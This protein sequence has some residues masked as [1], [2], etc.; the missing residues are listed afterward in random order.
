ME[1][2]EQVKPEAVA[3]PAVEP[4]PQEVKP[5]VQEDIVTRAARLSA[6]KKQEVVKEPVSEF[7]LAKED[8]DAV[9][10][11]PRTEKLY[12]SMQ[13]DYVKK[14]QAIAE[15]KR[16]LEAQKKS[17]EEQAKQMSAWTPDKLKQ[18]LNK[19]DFV[20]A[21]Q[22]VTGTQNPPNSGLTNEE[23]SALTDKEK[24][25][26]S[27]ATQRISNLEMQNWQM[28]Q[29]QQDEVLRNKYANYTPEVIDDTVGKLMRGEI[30]ADREI[31]YKA[32]FHDENVRN[33]YEMGKQDKQKEYQEK[34]GSMSVDGGF[35]T[36]PHN[37]TLKKE[38]KETTSSY[39]RRIAERR[40]AE[41]R[42]MTR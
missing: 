6:D 37:D 20:Q 30:K 13:A 11:D 35:S 42:Q 33:A 1:V 9:L 39:F 17:I 29:K 24:A 25:Q 3:T 5:V 32:L 26:L 38:E 10:K 7:S 2:Q 31:I 22:T 15:E 27:Q 40:L 8:F 36:V 41:S 19:P 12:K 16:Q 28:L 18:E 34:V 4:K 23:Y 14:T 21:I